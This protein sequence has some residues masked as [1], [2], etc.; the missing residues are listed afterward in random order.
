MSRG[1]CWRAAAVLGGLALTVAPWLVS[2]AA[3]GPDEAAKQCGADEV[4]VVVDYAE[5]GDGVRVA[6]ADNAGERA[7]E[8]FTRA[9][10]PLEYAVRSS[11]FVCRV[12]KAPADAG[13]VD[14]A[15]ATAY[16]SLWSSDGKSGTWSYATRGPQT[17]RVPAGGYL[18]FVWHEGS[19]PADPP[20]MAPGDAVVPEAGA[21]GGAPADGMAESARRDSDAGLTWWIPVGAGAVV[22]G[23]GVAVARKRQS[24]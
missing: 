21:E 10:F 3:S 13:C 15:P 14:A 11:G 20:A 4:T 22:V 7:S 19:G 23:A 2:A 8:L 9:G 6:C 16:W 5:L 18:A 12:S 17:L 24:V 1:W